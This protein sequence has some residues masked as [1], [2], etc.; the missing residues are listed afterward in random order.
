M[1]ANLQGNNSLECR[2]V[3]VGVIAV[4]S[5]VA[6][7]AKSAGGAGGLLKG[8]GALAAAGT[9][10]QGSCHSCCTSLSF[11][12]IRALHAVFESRPEYTPTYTHFAWAPGLLP[13][14]RHLI[15][16]PCAPTILLMRNVWRL[17]RL[18]NLFCLR[19]I[20]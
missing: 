12:K 1:Y 13:P 3:A 2:A 6:V 10:R 19:K 20:N 11:V 16:Q 5:K 18:R 7:I 17:R 15:L 4:G 8:V 14:Y 9:A